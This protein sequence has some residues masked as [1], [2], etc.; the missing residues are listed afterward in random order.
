[1]HSGHNA[2]K[3]SIRVNQKSSPKSKRVR[4]DCKARDFTK[5]KRKKKRG[6]VRRKLKR[7]P[8]RLNYLEDAW[9]LFK[10]TFTKA[11]I[12]YILLVRKSTLRLW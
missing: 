4:F 3:L 1:M 9:E 2:I 6:L 12:E 10:I 11:Q 5:E 7:K 8:K